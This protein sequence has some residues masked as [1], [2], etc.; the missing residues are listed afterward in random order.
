MRMLMTVQMDTEATTRAIH[1]GTMSTLVES[2]M[3]RFRPEA[4]YFS[5][6]HG[7]RTIYI[8]FDLDAE[9]RMIEIAE[10]FFSGLNAKIDFAPAMT[11]DD[12]RQGL[13]RLPQ[14]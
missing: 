5:T 12:V 3:E 13:G 14:A 4:V 7:N 2:T 9:V 1:D 11:P 10:P 6:H 8:V